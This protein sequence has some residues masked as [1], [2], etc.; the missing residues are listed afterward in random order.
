MIAFGYCDG[1]SA[2]AQ[3]HRKS[4]HH[5]QASSPCTLGLAHIC[6][7]PP[8][9]CCPHRGRSQCRQGGQQGDAPGLTNS[10]AQCKGRCCPMDT[11]PIH[12]QQEGSLTFRKLFKSLI[13]FLNEVHTCLFP[14]EINLRDLSSTPHCQIE[15]TFTS[16]TGHLSSFLLALGFLQ[17]KAKRSIFRHLHQ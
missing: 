5:H 3:G 1:A 16:F 7:S 2:K 11:T 12:P 4:L 15:V 14:A 8:S 10:P 6:T 17:A 9:Y 13:A